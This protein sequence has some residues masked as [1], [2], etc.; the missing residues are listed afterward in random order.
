M[1][2]IP[3]EGLKLAVFAFRSLPPRLQPAVRREVR[4][5]AA[6]TDEAS[7]PVRAAFFAYLDQTPP[8]AENPA[9]LRARINAFFGFTVFEGERLYEDAMAREGRPDADYVSFAAHAI[10]L[11]AGN[12]Y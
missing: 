4:E 3:G 8:T 11:L 2:L 12:N 7:D 9:A 6:L 10:S 5:P 1:F